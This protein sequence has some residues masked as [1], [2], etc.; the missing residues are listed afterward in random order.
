MAKV[1]NDEEIL[2]KVSIPRVRRTNVIDD[3]WI[4]ASKDPYV[5]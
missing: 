2:S 5:T 1:Q 3:R 4:C